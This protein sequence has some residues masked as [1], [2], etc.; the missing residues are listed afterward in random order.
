MCAFKCRQWHW[1]ICNVNN[2]DNASPLDRNPFTDSDPS[3]P[4]QHF[5]FCLMVF[6]CRRKY[7]FVSVSPSLLSTHFIC[8]GAPTHTQ[9]I[10]RGCHVLMV[11]P[12]PRGISLAKLNLHFELVECDATSSHAFSPFYKIYN[13]LEA[14]LI[15]YCALNPTATDNKFTMQH[16]VQLQLADS[17]WVPVSI[18]HCLLCCLHMNLLKTTS[19]PST[20]KSKYERKLW[21]LKWHSAHN[22]I[23]VVREDRLLVKH[24]QSF[25]FQN[26]LLNQKSIARSI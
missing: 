25:I 12:L 9:L 2:D 13:R 19:D 11:P 18:I 16:T 24:L 23:I 10:Q 6:R 5:F 14:G 8:A 20:M 15:R 21:N 26:V 3:I 1:L 7:R 4:L 22:V 17:I